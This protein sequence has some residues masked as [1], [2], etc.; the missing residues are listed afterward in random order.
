MNKTHRIAVS[1]LLITLLVSCAQIQNHENATATPNARLLSSVLVKPEDIQ[2]QWRW[3]NTF[4]EES[5]VAPLPDDKTPTPGPDD[6]ITDV[7]T[8]FGG[9]SEDYYFSF[10][11]I[12]KEYSSQEFAPGLQPD[13]SFSQPLLLNLNGIG[14]NLNYECSQNPLDA[15][16]HAFLCR[17]S[18]QYDN[19]E[20]FLFISGDPRIGQENIET[21]IRQILLTVEERIK[22]YQAQ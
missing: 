10:T 20:S 16:V 21:M 13:E 17:I 4:D 14:G 11:H 22:R 6:P 12:V 1:L 9:Y 7:F 8:A 15:P 19:I 2:G 5:S 3:T 18:V